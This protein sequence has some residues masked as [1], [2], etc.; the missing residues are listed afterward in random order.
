MNVS[1]AQLVLNKLEEGG[2]V[3]SFSFF[4]ILTK[5]NMRNPAQMKIHRDIVT[6][7]MLAEHNRI[8]EEE[9]IKEQ[10]ELL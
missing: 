9:R 2:M 10:S 6:G 8:K 7:R 4:Y 5:T 1:L 3:S